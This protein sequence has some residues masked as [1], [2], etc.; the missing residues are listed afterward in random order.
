M[1]ERSSEKITEWLDIHVDTLS[2]EER[3]RLI[4]EIFE[5]LTAQELLTI[6]DLAEQKR[7]S[8]LEDAKAALLAEMQG[9]VSELGLN[10]QDILPSRRARKNKS[11]V[12]VKYRS[13][14]GETWSGRGHAPLW[15][16]QLE[17]QGHNREEYKASEG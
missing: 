4:E 6:R 8:K 5:S 2:S 16:R 12:R 1:A 14:D 17:L 11:S 13:P 7:Q 9:K 3:I 15:L 10:L